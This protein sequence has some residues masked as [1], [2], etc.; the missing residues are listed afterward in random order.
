MHT[1]VLLH[2]LYGENQPSLK[3]E[4]WIK[5]GMPLPYPY[6]MNICQSLTKSSSPLHAF[7]GN[8]NFPFMNN[9]IPLPSSVPTASLLLST[10]KRGR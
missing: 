1:L 3:Q 9:G 5:I 6:R 8:S 10:A 7:R 2:I 4:T